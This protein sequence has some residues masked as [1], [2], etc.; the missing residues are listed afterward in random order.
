MQN[1]ITGYYMKYAKELE[2]EKSQKTCNLM[3]K[4]DVKPLNI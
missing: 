1:T 2:K 4:M 3:F